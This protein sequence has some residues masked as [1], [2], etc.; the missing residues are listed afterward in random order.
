MIASLFLVFTLTASRWGGTAQDV[1]WAIAADSNSV[2]MGG[3]QNWDTIIRKYSPNGTLIWNRQWQSEPQGGQDGVNAVALDSVG[4][5]FATG[6]FKNTINF[7][8]GPLVSAGGEDGFVL[9]LSPTGVHIWSRRFG[10]SIPVD[11]VGPHDRGRGIAVDAAGDVYVV[12]SFRSPTDFGNGLIPA[13]VG[14][15][16]FVVKYRGTDG[17]F[18]WV[19]V[20]TCDNTD[21]ASSV[22]VDEYGDVFV[23]GHYA[24]TCNWGLGPHTS[25][26]AG[27]DDFFL[28]KLASG[29]GNPLWTS[30]LPGS[31]I[32][33]RATGVATKLG[34]VYVTGYFYDGFECATNYTC[35]KANR[36]FAD[37]FLLHFDSYEGMFLDYKELQGTSEVF[38]NAVA[39]DANGVAVT[40]TFWGSLDLG[41]G[42]VDSHGD[43]D[44]FMARFDRALICTRSDGFGG[45]SPDAG[46][47]AALAP[48]GTMWGTGSFFGTAY[49]GPISLTAAG[50]GGARDGWVAGVSP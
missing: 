41:C 40:G 8:G 44:A 34:D 31:A 23:A 7:G 25:T 20:P 1:G 14:S 19:R 5:V 17:A 43:Y 42:Q 48:N 16:A 36:Y 10:G 50:T 35:M 6:N 12:G 11:S 18:L 33:D 37:G 39:A 15:N 27:Y 3:T 26:G 46:Q 28:V 4:N 32:T 38:A 24:W 45:M 2:V 29:T 49:F 21:L 47:G 30:Y 9:K 13:G 22:A